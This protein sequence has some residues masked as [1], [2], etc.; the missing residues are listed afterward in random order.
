MTKSPMTDSPFATSD[1][2]DAANAAM[3]RAF[4]LA[5]EPVED[6]FGVKV[7]AAVASRQ[8][9]YRLGAGVRAVAMAVAGAAGGYGL[10]L[11]G[12]VLMPQIQAALG[13]SLLALVTAQAPMISIGAP[14]VML[15]GAAAGAGAAYFSRD[16]VSD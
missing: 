4:A 10:L 14:L 16:Q 7:S 1:E 8:R 5:D 12:G 6:G 15:L 2:L 11:V 3:R 13:P 9:R